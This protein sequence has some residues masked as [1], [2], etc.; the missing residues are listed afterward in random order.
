VGASSNTSVASA[1]PAGKLLGTYTTDINGIVNVT[2]PTGVYEVIETVA[3][4][5][6]QIDNAKQDVT[7]R[8]G[9]KTSVT[10]TDTK[11]MGLQVIKL[12]SQSKQPLQGAVFN[13]NKTNSDATSLTAGSSPTGD[14]VGTY[15]TDVNGQININNLKSGEYTVTEVT[16]P[17][18]Y[19]LDSPVQN[20]KIEAGRLASITFTDT[21][22]SGLQIKK[23][24]SVTKQPIA[25]VVF[26][27]SKMSGEKIGDFT[28][29]KD[30][31]IF[32]PN[33]DTGWF[34]LVE[35]KTAD[36]YLLDAAPRN[37]EIKKGQNT[38][39]EVENTPMSGLLI[40][41]TDAQTGKPLTGV[42][43][44]VRRADGQFV[45][46]NI[47]DMNQ[48]NTIANS[49]NKTT[50]AN[51]D[52]TGSYTT[53]NNG[54]I[55]INTIT[56]GEY[57]VIE[58]KQLPGY[59]LDTEV[60]AVTITPGKLL[61]LQLTNKPLAG[62][63]IHKYDSITKQPIFNVEFEVFDSNNKVIGNFY[64]DNNGMI[65]FSAIL[66]EGRYT[67]R[68]TRPAAGYYR[69]DTPRTVEFVA[70]KITTIEW[71]NTPEA[72]QIQITKLSADANEM[73]G[74]DAGTPL[75]GAIF[76]VTDYK[77]G[78]VIDKFITNE[79]GV[80]VS[81]PLPL[82]R[83]LVKEKQAPQFYKLNTKPIDLTIEFANQ[84][85]KA[86][87]TDESAN[88]GVS[89]DKVGPQEV[90]QGQQA[91][92]TFKTV[93]ND[94]TVQL[95]DFFWRDVLPTDA[96]R[97]NK[98][99]TGTYSQ[100]VKYKILATTNKGNTIIVADN[101]KTTKNNVI[102]CTN[103]E[104]GLANDEYVTSFT[105]YFGAVKAGFTNVENPQVY[106]DVLN[107]NLPNGYKFANKADI[108]GKD[109]SGSWVIGNSTCVTVIF[110]PTPQKL[111]KTG[112]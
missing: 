3:P 76:E 45:A 67:L 96:V 101:L 108:G 51:G 39:I 37:V 50:S 105:L 34:T 74:L 60:H 32:V 49:P 110:N 21:K 100:S 16:P 92:Y 82:G 35:E 109:Q 68:E 55:L 61:T 86:E 91:V 80:G 8:A 57:Q 38:V 31:L 20:V 66:T 18:G 70:G 97:I 85:V 111:P 47:L 29:D 88:T 84:I 2:V 59:E 30:G 89:I 5:G 27:L 43:F 69:D 48:P 73:N 26:S 72:G 93:R 106:V 13:I 63:K 79:D 40:I 19:A 17:T 87:F 9:Q 36:G 102:G 56:A 22:V 98:I 103:A 95:T 23:L 71:A 107:K 28:T 58:R 104:L 4:N 64:T 14:L 11:V 94:S 78:N 90:M 112:S 42:V 15:T 10:Y 12:D 33:L 81:R 77:T 99:V 1:S 25:G 83:Y 62:L 75:Q 54:R 52:I 65:D 6:Y 53:D 24:N 7:V 41:K 44:D 46:G